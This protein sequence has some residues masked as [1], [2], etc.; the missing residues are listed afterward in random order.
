ME[1]RQDYPELVHDKKIAVTAEAL[2]SD[3]NWL[4]SIFVQICESDRDHRDHTRAHIR[5]AIREIAACFSVYRTYIYPERGDVPELDAAVIQSAIDVGAKYR[6]DID[7]GLY[8]FIGDV[9]LL[10]RKGPLEVRLPSP[11]SAIHQPSHGQGT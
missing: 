5:H 6:P 3:V 2:G 8:D 1:S 11:F 4:T 10:R 9:L 7:R